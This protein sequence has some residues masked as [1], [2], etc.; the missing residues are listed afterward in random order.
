MH[1]CSLLTARDSS[2]LTFSLSKLSSSQESKNKGN[3]KRLLIAL[4]NACLVPSL[5]VE[6]RIRTASKPHEYFVDGKRG[7]EKP[8]GS[9]CRRSRN[10]KET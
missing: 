1:T 10:P 3:F 9:A 6:Y 2:A 5:A 8:A 7:T 4:V